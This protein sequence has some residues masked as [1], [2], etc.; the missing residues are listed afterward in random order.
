MF[1]MIYKKNIKVGIKFTENYNRLG[2]DKF[3]EDNSSDNVDFVVSFYGDDD[4]DLKDRIKK[5]RV[6]NV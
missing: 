1:N 5:F 3:Y 4:K 6:Y 2:S